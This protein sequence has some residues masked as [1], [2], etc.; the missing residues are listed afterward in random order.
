MSD[1]ST[2]TSEILAANLLST[3]VEEKRCAVFVDSTTDLHNLQT[4]VVLGSHIQSQISFHELV[5]IFIPDVYSD[6]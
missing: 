6:N 3:P 5:I 2:G 4:C 1:L